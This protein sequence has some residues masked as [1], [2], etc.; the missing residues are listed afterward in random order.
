MK[1][2]CAARTAL[3]REIGAALPVSLIL[4]VLLTLIVVSIIKSSNVNSKVAGNMQIQ[5]ESE[6]AAQQAVEAVISTPFY[7]APASSV[8]AVDI[9]NDGANDYS[10]SVSKPSCQTVKPIKLSELDIANNSD[11]PCFSSGQMQNSGIIG[12]GGAG[13]LGN[14]LCANQVWDI[15]AATADLH[16]SAAKVETH[17][18]VGVRVAVGTSCS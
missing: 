13:S 14:S 2:F 4:L 16:G 17:Q 7:A 5:K 3:R 11:Q 18:G 12:A 6:A 1:T 15:D 9:D 8:V 10:V